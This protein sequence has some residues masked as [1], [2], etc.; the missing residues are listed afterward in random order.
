[1][2]RP[3]SAALPPTAAVVLTGAPGAGKSS[4]LQ[5]LT[6][7]L[8]LEAIP[9]G[10]L[11]SEQLEWG[12]PWLDV[13][14]GARQLAAVVALQREAGRRRFVI[15]ATTETA[16]WLDAILGAIGAERS[17]VACLRAP[18][19][20]LARRIDRREPDAWPGKQELIDHAR[21]LAVAI[22]ALP[23]LDLVV[24]TDG[25]DPADVAAEIRDAIAAAGILT[26]G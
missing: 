1:M 18:A 2:P 14:A 15:T 24:D 19:D 9:Y 3:V 11:E 7:L 5:A 4:V 6:T 26:D 16:A 21:A 8:E 20:E 22:P 25:R 17:F 23:G 12:L 13:A 10:A